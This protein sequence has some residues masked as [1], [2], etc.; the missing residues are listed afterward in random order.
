[1]VEKVALG[2]VCGG[3]DG[4]RIDLWWKCWYLERFVVDKVALG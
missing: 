1:V 3:K 2:G 4:T